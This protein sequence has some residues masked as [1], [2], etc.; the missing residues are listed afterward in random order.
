MRDRDIVAL[1]TFALF[2]TEAYAH[3]LVAK[4]EGSEKFKFYIPTLN[5]TFK[6]LA[7]VGT[8]SIL[9]GILV[10]KIKKAL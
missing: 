7:V 1:V 4:N 2:S 5:T 3:Y 10:E 6:N 9:N 8:F